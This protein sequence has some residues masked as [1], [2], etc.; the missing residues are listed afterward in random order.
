MTYKITVCTDGK[1]YLL[2][3]PGS[4]DLQL[5]DPVVTLELNSSGSLSFDVPP[6]HPYRDKI[7][8][9]SSEFFVYQNE[10][11]IFRGRS[12]GSEEDYYK[13]GSITCEGDL[14]Y[15]LDSIQRP[16]DQTGSIEEF[17]TA[18]LAAHNEQVEDRKQY[19]NGTVNV[20][21]NTSNQQRVT[22]TCTTTLD[23]LKTQLVDHH[24]G[25]LRS[26]LED[27]KRYLDY[28]VDF[29][30]YNSQPI[31]FRE[32]L[33]DIS[34]KKDAT[35]IRTALIPYGA[36][37]DTTNADGTTGSRRVD[38][39]SVN[40]GKDYIYNQ[41]AVNKY[42]WI[43]A[44]MTWDEITDP[45]VLKNTAMTY[46]E[47]TVSLPET[48]EL[49]AVDLSLVDVEVAA[50]KLGYWTRVVSEPH[51]LSGEYL[52]TKKVLHL[53]EPERDKVVLGGAIEG[54]AGSTSKDMADITLKVQEISRQT[55]TELVN[56][57]NNATKLITGGLGGYVLIGMADD[58][59]P[60]E[61]V[62]MDTPNVST[63]RNVFR[64]NKNG[65]G[66]SSTGY[67]GV[68]RNAW[69]IDGNLVADFI[70]VGTMLCDRIRG[71]T[72]EVGGKGTGKDGV[73]LIRD[74][75]GEIVGRFDKNGIAILSGNINITSGSINL[76]KFKVTSSGVMSLDGTSNNTSIGCNV[77]NANHVEVHEGLECN[78][79]V[80]VSG[81]CVLNGYT[82]ANKISCYSIYSEL[83]GSTW[84]DKRLKKG[85]RTIE[86]KD[87][88]RVING[89]KGVYYKTKRSGTPAIG[90]VAQDVVELLNKL[91]L[92]YPL[93]DRHDG[94]LALQYQNLIPI[95]AGALQ[96]QQKEID[97]LREAIKNG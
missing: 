48:L 53:T 13:T 10:E 4:D 83:A 25:Y 76:G 58:G 45:A 89:L 19:L 59:H 71:G 88:C 74:V 11:E 50:L 70:T 64:I 73:I 47:D 17:F 15:L 80:T 63:A 12:T 92:N 57:I 41:E 95:L 65:L 97:T 79:G 60:D 82:T 94:Y 3:Q 40:G 61:I 75:N 8:P 78:S 6:D 34:R 37:I 22:D 33:L 67:N 54:I 14:A 9:L 35:T 87:C 18:R 85:I 68:Y 38:I 31:R 27:G 56:K 86:P 16:Y 36:Q 46:L 32:N 51:G 5:I 21:D 84:S 26:R 29:G 66:F 7:K 62:I 39:T 72:L 91:N 52:L 93:V 81:P 1:V 28:L 96:A 20:V 44:N 2:Y 55:T 77:L 49:T 43:W 90:F 42:G 69:T 23:S 30:G 24:G